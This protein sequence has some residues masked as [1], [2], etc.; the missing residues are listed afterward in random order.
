MTQEAARGTC[1]GLTIMCSEHLGLSGLQGHGSAGAG[2][3]P[4]QGAKGLNRANHGRQLGPAVEPGL[5]SGHWGPI[6]SKYI[7]L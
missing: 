4:G 7:F 2:V 5:S 1:P 3:A 6:H